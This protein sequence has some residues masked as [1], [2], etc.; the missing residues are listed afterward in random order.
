MLK[1]YFLEI[2]TT[3]I[4]ELVKVG[5]LGQM[6]ENDSFS[7]NIEV[8]KNTEY[9]DFAVNVS[10]LARYAKLPPAKIAEIISENI[11]KTNFDVNIVAG[12]INFSLKNSVFNEILFSVLDK[13]LDYARNNKGE[14]KGNDD[15]KQRL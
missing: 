14:N 11:S 8:P 1:E 12:F 7:L 13:K 10:S 9:G 3:S 6:S 4:N 5:K 2:V 15:N